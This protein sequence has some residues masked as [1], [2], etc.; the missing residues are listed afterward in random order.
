MP[1]DP[2]LSTGARPGWVE[3]MAGAR[4]QHQKRA[5]AM[6]SAAHTKQTGRSAPHSHG[7]GTATTLPPSATPSAG[8]TNS[9]LAWAKPRSMFAPA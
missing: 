2:A 7:S 8:I 6:I 3:I 1:C 4:F 5:P 9:T